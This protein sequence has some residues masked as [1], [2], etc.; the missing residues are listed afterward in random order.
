ME[1]PSMPRPLVPADLH[2]PSEALIAAL[3]RCALAAA[4]GDAKAAQTLRLIFGDRTIATIEAPEA[5]KA[6]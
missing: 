3:A 2:S 5:D 1:N 4:R 6:A